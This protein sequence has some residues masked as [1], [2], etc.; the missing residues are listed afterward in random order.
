MGAGISKLAAIA[1]MLLIAVVFSG[2]SSYTRPV[3]ETTQFSKDAPDAIVIIGLQSTTPQTVF[4]FEGAHPPITLQWGRVAK[5]F[6][7]PTKGEAFTID[8]ITTLLGMHMGTESNM[9]IHVMRI[10]AGT[11]ML[12]YISTYS[13]GGTV[14]YNYHTRLN[15]PEEA[16]FFTIK[17]GDVRYLGDFHV[18]AISRPAKIERVTR[19]DLLAKAELYKSPGIRVRPFFQEP[20]Y[21]SKGDTTRA[22]AYPVTSLAATKF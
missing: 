10:P 5:G 17:P 13:G 14:F 9:S 4:G 16:P 2:C 11:Y 15:L 19:N 12:R 6:T 3:D 20:S 1:A 22:L 18:N 7:T 8:N 21:Y